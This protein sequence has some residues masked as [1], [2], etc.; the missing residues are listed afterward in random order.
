MAIRRPYRDQALPRLRRT[1]K[2]QPLLAVSEPP[3][4][5]TRDDHRTRLR[6]RPP[7]PGEGDHPGAAL[8]LRVRHRWHI[9]QPAH[10]RPRRPRLSTRRSRPAPNRLPPLQQSAW[11]PVA[12]RYRLRCGSFAISLVGRD[13]PRQ[14]RRAKTPSKA[15]FTPGLREPDSRVSHFH[16]PRQRRA[17]RR[18]LSVSGGV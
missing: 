13:D 16:V 4:R 10:R 3:C 15:L 6:G 14:V 12:R 17:S 8:V 2:G 1:H 11:Q 5:R 7:A 18:P 9:R